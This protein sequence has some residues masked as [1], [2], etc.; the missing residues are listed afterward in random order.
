MKPTVDIVTPT[1][2]RPQLLARAI[3]SVLSQT[4]T[5]WRLTVV[6]DGSDDET[7]AIIA[8]FDDDRIRIF[9][10][11]HP[12]GR[13]GSLRRRAV[14][15][16]TAPLVAYLDDDDEFDDHHLAVASARFAREHDLDLL[17]TC[18]RYVD[19]SGLMIRRTRP[20][21]QCWHPELQTVA[22][23]FE[24]SR[25]VHRRSAADAAGGWSVEDEDFEDWSLWRRMERAGT[26]FGTSAETTVRIGVSAGSRQ[27][28]MRPRYALRLAEV[29]PDLARRQLQ[30]DGFS[31]ML[32]EAD[33]A[34]WC[35][36]FGELVSSGALV[37]PD[38]TDVDPDDG[39][40]LHL[41][42]PAGSDLMIVG[43][44][45]VGRLVRPVH[46]LSDDH[47]SEIRAVFL[48][49][50]PRWRRALRGL[51]RRTGSSPRNEEPPDSLDAR[52][53]ASP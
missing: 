6:L 17:A 40:P 25:V 8:S 14:E 11:T 34:D 10:E 41:A 52:P 9:V 48:Q 33:R 37:T 29:E 3:R 50:R 23:M 42:A 24:P 43:T 47:A 35:E 26:R 2:G 19:E 22:A 4:L 21:E 38:G 46:A 27:Q 16:A 18:A 49:R 1:R 32:A 7:S 36:W 51:D 15:A 44:G 28:R 5:D 39:V 12:T 13:P 45:P 30:D 53:A 31:T 20:V